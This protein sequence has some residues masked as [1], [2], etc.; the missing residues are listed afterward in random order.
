M[1]RTHEKHAVEPPE[2]RMAHEGQF[3]ASMYL[4]RLQKAAKGRAPTHVIHVERCT[5]ELPDAARVLVAIE[6]DERDWLAN[7]ITGALFDPVTLQCAGSTHVHA[8][9]IS[10]G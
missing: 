10:H 1:K 8:S 3:L 9:A 2:F 6:I 5:G 4:P 7:P